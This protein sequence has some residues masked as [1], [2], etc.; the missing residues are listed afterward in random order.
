MRLRVILT[1]VMLVGA[2]QLLNTTAEGRL[3]AAQPPATTENEGGEQVDAKPVV[4][5]TARESTNEPSGDSRAIQP[6]DGRDGRDL[7]LKSYRP[8]S[9]LVVPQT[10]MTH[11]S[12]PVIDC[13]SHFFYKLR[14]NQQAFVDYLAA[15]DRNQIAISVSLDGQ[16]GSQLDEHI[17]F[18]WTDHADRFA[19][20]A[21]VDWRGSGASD[22]PATWD[23]LRPGFS[24]RTADQLADA[25]K[26]GVSGLKVFK[27]LGLEY[28]DAD[29][30][31]LKV[32]DPRWDAIWQRCGQ[33]GIPVLMHTGDPQAFF[34]PIDET[35]ER[36]EELSRHPDWSFFGPGF[37][38]L[39]ELQQARNRVL[40]RH[41]KTNFIAAHMANSPE[42]LQQLA[43]WLDEHP[44][45]YV[46]LSSRISELGRQPYT[47]RDFLI[48]YQD[49]VLFGTDGPWP[50]QRL[51]YY[52]RFLETRDQS[53]PYS[54]KQPPPQGFWA[55]YGI[56]LPTEVLK[57]I[58]HGNALR[59]IPGLMDKFSR[60]Q[61]N[62]ASAV[63]EPANGDQDQPQPS[64]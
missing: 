29:G 58:Y 52:W 10:V 16:L 39:L 54:E 35:N 18:L 8:K 30:S 12:L 25:V 62:Q 51:S 24:E 40:A 2:A 36:W 5:Q 15:M 3:Q 20:F 45:L 48:R 55:I 56:E 21:N 41:P 34:E 7:S 9:Q 59:I 60:W 28:R 27:Q 64:E 6:L 32:D 1:L 17:R 53:F 49:R 33:L 44:N 38:T 43:Q 61:Q 13:H 11:A 42:D 23:C 63:A 14:H 57:K 19:I 22:Q 46:D 31:L 26:R 4:V 47:A 37:P 50:E